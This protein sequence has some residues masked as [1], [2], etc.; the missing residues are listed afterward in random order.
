[1][2]N[3]IK[4][5]WFKLAILILAMAFLFLYGYGQNISAKK[6]NLDVFKFCKTNSVEVCE[7]LINAFRTP[8]LF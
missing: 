2:K 6:Q 4:E 5:N 7:A 3:F 8:P 1:M